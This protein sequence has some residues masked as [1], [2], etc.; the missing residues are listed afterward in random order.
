M[1]TTIGPPKFWCIFQLIFA[2]A[3]LDNLRCVRVDP[4]DRILTGNLY[5]QYTLT[6][7][8]GLRAYKA[9]FFTRKQLV[10]LIHGVRP[11]CG[12]IRFLG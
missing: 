2:N 8:S 10:R 3:I 6:V 7:I 5:V 1:R 11:I 4:D 12:Q 9:R